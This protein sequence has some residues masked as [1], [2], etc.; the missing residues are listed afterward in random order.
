MD[1]REQKADQNQGRLTAGGNLIKYPGKTTRKMEDLMTSKVL[2]NSVL[3]AKLAKYICIDIKNFYLC[4]RMDRYEYMHMPLGI[5]LEHV[6]Q[7]Y[8]SRSKA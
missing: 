4:A 1:Y 6:I 5:S 7:Q 3:S 2:W 8:N